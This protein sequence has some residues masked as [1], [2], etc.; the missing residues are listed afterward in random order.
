M[1][2]DC[3]R[4]GDDGEHR[5]CG[6]D[7]IL[8][9]LL[10][11]DAGE[12]GGEVDAVEDGVDLQDGVR[13]G[14]KS[15]PGVLVGGTYILLEKGTQRDIIDAAQRAC[16]LRHCGGGE[17]HAPANDG[18]Q[19]MVSAARGGARQGRR[20]DVRGELLEVVGDLHG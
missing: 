15:T 19:G 20:D 5:L 4:Y 3:R 7:E 10:G 14:G 6:A 13:G 18:S 2:G 8:A 16:S 11:M 1:R 12:G 9:E 17:N